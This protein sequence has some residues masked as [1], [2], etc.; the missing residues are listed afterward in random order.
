MK[1][2][3]FV[4]HILLLQDLFPD[5]KFIHLVR[6]ARYCANSMIKLYNLCHDQLAY[7]RKSHNPD[8]GDGREFVPYPHLR[9]FPEYMSKYGPGDIRM[10]AHLWND[11]IHFMNER[12]KDVKNLYDIRYEDILTHP[13]EEMSK[14]FDF[15]ELAPVSK[16]NGD[17]WRMIDGVGKISHRNN[18]AHFD[19][20]EKI[21]RETMRQ[22]GYAE[23]RS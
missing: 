4:P 13:T 22:Y 1:M 7:I 17:Y 10:A 11:S 3:G 14:I 15:C 18:Y 20:I 23:S 8:L 9:K 12:R 21:C 5:A 2:P 19:V 6:D 16:D